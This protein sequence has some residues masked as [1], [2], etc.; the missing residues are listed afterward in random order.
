MDNRAV[1]LGIGGADLGVSVVDGSK[2]WM[3]FG[4]TASTGPAGAGP[5]SRRLVGASSAIESQLHFNCSSYS[6][7]STSGG[8]CYEP[9]HSAGKAGIDAST[10][11]AGAITL[12]G[13][14]YI[15]SMQ[16]NQWG[17]GSED[18]HAHGILFKEQ[19]SRTV[20]E[21]TRW[22]IAT[23]CQIVTCLVNLV[24]FIRVM[25]VAENV[26]LRD[27]ITNRRCDY[28]GYSLI[29]LKLLTLKINSQQNKCGCG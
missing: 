13:S 26:L 2:L 24:K 16:V 4:D 11:P 21:L 7:L 25:P 1:A 27:T 6:W 15:Y 10:V 8:K 5:G 29:R 18:I 17:S 14:I 28:F 22:P 9:L 23:Q 19:A 20:A 12:N 3:I